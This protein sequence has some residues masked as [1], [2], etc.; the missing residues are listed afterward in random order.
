MTLENIVK[1]REQHSKE[2]TYVVYAFQGASVYAFSGM[3][4]TIWDDTNEV[5]HFIRVATPGTPEWLRSKNQI[6]IKSVPYVFIVYMSS[7]ENEDKFKEKWTAG[8]FKEYG[9]LAEKQ[10]KILDGFAETLQRGYNPIELSKDRYLDPADDLPE[11]EDP[12][13]TALV[14][15]GTV[16]DMIVD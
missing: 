10:I 9:L 14:D 2:D 3:D 16:D 7:C 12:I 6:C 4:F 15:F 13:T 1:F 5:L 11:G 8:Y